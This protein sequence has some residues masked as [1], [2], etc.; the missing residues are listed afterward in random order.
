MPTHAGSCFRHQSSGSL[1]QPPLRFV[2]ISSR[3][4]SVRAE[5][6]C[7]P[8]SEHSKVQRN[9]GCHPWRTTL[10]PNQEAYR[11]SKLFSWCDIASSALRQSTWLNC[12]VL[13]V[14]P[15]VGKASGL[16]PEA[17]SSFLVSDSEHLVPEPLLSR[18]LSFGTHSHWTLDNLVTIYCN[19]KWN[20]KH[21]CSSSSE[22]FCG[23]YLMKGLTSALYYYY[24]YYYICLEPKIHQPQLIIQATLNLINS[25]SSSEQVS[26]VCKHNSFEFDRH[27]V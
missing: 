23:S 16:L 6:C 17:T 19:S 3:P 12:V 14:L 10:A 9:L 5:F 24:Y 18:A 20:W 8:C 4:A 25:V 2:F 27:R 15:P 22:R 11:V 13:L 1:Q 26:V 21:F 7:S